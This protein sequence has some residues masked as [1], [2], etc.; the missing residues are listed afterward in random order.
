MPDEF[1][2]PLD[3]I[4]D[5]TEYFNSNGR[6]VVDIAVFTGEE[7]PR[8]ASL[9]DRLVSSLPGIFGNEVIES[10]RDRLMNKGEPLR[11]MP[12]GVKHSEN[13]ADPEDWI[14]PLRGYKYDSF[15]RDVLLQYAKV[16]NGRIE[17][18]GGASYGLPV[19]STE[20]HSILL[21]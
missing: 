8:C 1:C 10:E 7:T 17:L 14:D 6:P 13:M 12:W 18:P 20:I 15:N 21:K 5:I 2:V 3:Q 11:E 9:P 4:V 16:R 19:L